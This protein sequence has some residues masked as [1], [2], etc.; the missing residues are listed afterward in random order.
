[1]DQNQQSVGALADTL[2]QSKIWHF[3]WD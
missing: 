3:W 1:M 2:R